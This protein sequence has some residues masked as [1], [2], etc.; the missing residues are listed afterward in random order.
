MLRWL[1]VPLVLVALGLAGVSM[2]EAHPFQHSAGHSP[3]GMMSDIAHDSQEC[4]NEADAEHITDA[5]SILGHCVVCTVGNSAA[6]VPA[7][8]PEACV[9]LRM[10]S[11]PS[12]HDSG[13]ARHPPKSSR[14][15]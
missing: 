5:C 9:G 8:S 10:T 7:L 2:A 11:L 6:S 1:I 4:C 3:F 15:V 13:P 14:Q 12:G